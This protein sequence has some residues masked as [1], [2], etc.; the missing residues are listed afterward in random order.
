MNWFR[1]IMILSVVFVTGAC[2]DDEPVFSEH[3]IETFS[4]D[5]AAPEIEQQGGVTTTYTIPDF[6][7][8]AYRNDTW[9]SQLIMDNVVVTRTGVNS[10][11]YS[12]PV[13][14]PEDGSVDFFAISPS[15]LRIVNNQWWFHT[16]M[17]HSKDAR[18][19]MLVAVK[20]D[21]WQSSGRIKLNFR[22]ALAKIDVKLK[23]SDP[24]VK[25][26]V[27]DVTICNV[28]TIGEF[29]FPAVTTSP[30]T[31]N[32]EL[33]GYWKVYSSHHEVKVF[34]AGGGNRIMLSETPVEVTPEKLFMIPIN[35]VDKGEFGEYHDGTIIK[36]V[37]AARG[38][39]YE[40]KVLLYDATPDHRWIPGR[41]YDYIIDV[42][43]PQ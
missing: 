37:Y 25:V 13:N 10:W 41:S 21:V 17:Y 40:A 3:S 34:S 24:T 27:S 18:T 29:K 15:S 9:G 28:D 2:S 42:L 23:C 31:N 1:F 20:R 12:P 22:H 36:I 8:S 33:F 35:L 26:G 32:G 16:I 11:T 43:P 19:D 7:V 14:W 39:D 5:A 6:R 30:D 4:F 38:K